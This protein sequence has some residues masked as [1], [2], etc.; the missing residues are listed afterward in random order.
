MKFLHTSDWHIGKVLKGRS[1]LDEQRAVL[2]EIVQV[3]RD[4]RVD[5]VL[6]A[7]DLYEA[8]APSAD[9]QQLLVQALLTLRRTGAEVIAIA[10][11]HDHAPTFDAYRPLMA[12][13]GITL[14]GSVRVAAD[15]GVVKFTARSTR[16]PVTVALLPFLSQRY[17]VRAAQLVS[18][19]P[20][21]AATGY[22]R[23]VRNLLA[24]LA[25]GFRD[26]AVNL[27]MAHLMVAGGKFGGGER[28]AQSFL[29]YWVPADAFPP[30]AHYVAL[31]HLHRRQSLSAPCPV[32]YCGSPITLDFGEQ[33]DPS[34]VLVVEAGVGAPARIVAEVPIGS[35]R[36]LR[37]VRGTVE[38]LTRRADSLGD[39]YLRVLLCEPARAG[40]RQEVQ[41]LLPNALE[42]RIDPEFAAPVHT[43]GSSA[44]AD[45]VERSPAELF[46]AYC[47]TR[48]LVDERVE[49][50]FARLHDQ[51]TT[52]HA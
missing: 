45:G 4:H 44:P 52:A 22:G 31:G 30:E 7:G 8:S 27:V 13:A 51:V 32:H 29:E 47:V 5:A 48:N 3:T 19:T 50:L 21:E 42:V 28:S 24:A 43:A 41:R 10:G 33:D 46:H 49:A 39:D 12:S 1:R 34:M 15:G 23:L 17:A 16:E 11:N 38:E 37:T 9:A 20:R 2:R 6:V 18:T 14:A 36:R 26:D 40:L 35:G 25:A